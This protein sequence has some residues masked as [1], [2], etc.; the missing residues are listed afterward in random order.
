ME[1]LIFYRRVK[2]RANL[3]N[4]MLARRATVAVLQTL[5]WRLPEAQ[6]DNIEANLPPELQKIWR[7]SLGMRLSKKL[8]RRIDKLDK[9]QFVSRIQDLTRQGTTQ[10]AEKLAAAVLHV[11]KEAIPLGETKHMLTQFPPDLKKFIKAA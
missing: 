2:E 11:L 3:P 1:A 8:L 7:G 4:E 10:A 6:A 5:H 9:G